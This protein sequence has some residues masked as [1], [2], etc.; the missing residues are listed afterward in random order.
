MGNYQEMMDVFNKKGYHAE[1]F[2]T[3]EEAKARV[4]ELVDG[5][6]SVGFGGSMTLNEMGIYDAVVQHAEATGA[7]IYGS[8]YE[9]QKEAPDIAGMRKKAIF[10]DVYL[11]STN[12]LTTQGDLI[13]IDAVGNRVAAMFFGP[14]DVIVVCGTNKIVDNPHQAIAR[15]KQTASPKNT[16]RLNCNTPCFRTGKCNENEC[17]PPGRI[18][19]V[20]VRIQFPPRDVNMHVLLVEG[21]YGY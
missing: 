5:A 8:Q 1:Y 18:C 15:I 11:T 14:K 2:A 7:E 21:D 9:E 19:K 6:Q 10:S 3:P 20:T 13:N 17:T 4:M 16:K 12:A